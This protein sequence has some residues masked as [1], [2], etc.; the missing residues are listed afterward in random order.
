[1]RGGMTVGIPPPAEHN[2]IVRFLG[3]SDRKQI[4]SDHSRYRRAVKGN[5]AYNMMRMWQGAAGVAPIDGLVSPAYE[6]AATIR[7]LA[8]RR[9]NEEH[10]ASGDW[11][12]GGKDTLADNIG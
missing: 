11:R 4:I 8:N 5:I 3:Y 10:D 9:F 12:C 6:A 1:M 2:D 7:P